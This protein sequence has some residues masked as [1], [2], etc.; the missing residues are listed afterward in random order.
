M[1]SGGDALSTIVCYILIVFGWCWREVE[2]FSMSKGGRDFSGSHKLVRRNV[3]EAKGA[4]AAK[5]P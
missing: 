2:T 4:T 3:V 5:L 1:L